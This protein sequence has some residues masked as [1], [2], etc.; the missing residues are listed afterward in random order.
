MTIEQAKQVNIPA[1]IYA[2]IKYQNSFEAIIK[3]V[4]SLR[5]HKLEDIQRKSRKREIAETRQIIYYFC[6]KYKVGTQEMI[7][8]LFNQDHS[9]LV[10]AR[11]QVI[12]FEQTN[13]LFRNQIELI[14]SEIIKRLNL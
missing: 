4:I 2:G 11:K 12:A 13:R 7:T 10:H 3:S 6:D 5:N 14:E 9:T 1:E 8:K